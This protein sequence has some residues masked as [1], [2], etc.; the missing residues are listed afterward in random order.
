MTLA[1][2]GEGRAAVAV[3]PLLVLALPPA[4]VRAYLDW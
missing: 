4:R 2:A 3:H 1:T